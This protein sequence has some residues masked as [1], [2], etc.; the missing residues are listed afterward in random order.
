MRTW[1]IGIHFASHHRI[2]E[3][4]I[5]V[6]REGS[7]HH[8]W[9]AAAEGHDPYP[10]GLLPLYRARLAEFSGAFGEQQFGRRLIIDLADVRWNARDLLWA[11]KKTAVVPGDD[12]FRANAARI[13]EAVRRQ[14]G[15]DQELQVW[16]N[17]LYLQVLAT[18]RR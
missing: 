3:G 6:G 9:L 7:F 1:P 13:R 5:E 11:D 12:V 15:I 4:E 14:T 2:D 17:D 16:G 18:L 10:N 8:G